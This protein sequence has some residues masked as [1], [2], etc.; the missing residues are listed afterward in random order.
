MEKVSWK[1]EGMTCSNCALSVNKVLQKQGMQHI[2]VNPI[3]GDVVFETV[4]ANGNVEKAKKNIEL[5]G[6]KVKADN[7][8]TTGKPAKRFLGTLMQKFWFCL[9]FTVLLMAG[10]LGMV[11]NLHFLH[12][13]VFQ[14][15]L[16][17]PVYIVGMSYF[18]KSAI[19]SLRSGVPN[20]N[21]LIALGATAAFIYSLIGLITT[22]T[23]K[24]FFETSASIINIVFL[25]SG[26]NT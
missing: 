22:D 4:S 9:P 21:V 18:G 24:I 17:L 23:T 6:Y 25:V 20:M 12:N 2:A 3:S 11:F 5:L 14:L 13:P 16:C 10:H 15:V 19:N 26:L 7:T 1:V 8:E